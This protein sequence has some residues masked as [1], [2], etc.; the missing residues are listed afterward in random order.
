M[1]RSAL[2]LLENKDSDALFSLG[3]VLSELGRHDESVDAYRQGLTLNGDDAELCY[4]LAIKVGSMGRTSE[5]M[6][7]Y[8][9]ATQVD[10]SMG[11]AWLNWGTAL[12]EFGD[13]ESAEAKFL[14][15]ID[16][17]G[18]RDHD[19]VAAK[20]MMNLSILYHKVGERSAQSNDV[21]TAKLMATKAGSM[22]D[23]AKRRLDAILQSSDN[24]NS[25]ELEQYR[26]QFPSLRVRCH[27]LTGQLFA[28]AGSLTEAEAEFAKA[29]QSFPDDPMAWMMLSRVQQ[30]QGNESGAA[31]A[32]AN[33]A[34][35]QPKQ[36]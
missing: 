3:L 1:L 22:A 6:E 9:R 30:L 35:L 21:S 10:P 28:A 20:A 31:H 36:T 12:A 32:M 24:S 26:A 19:A 25:L 16:C 23:D 14:R 2:E 17:H 7:L 5:E 33:V 15:A 11:G 29:T 8:D 13:L 27:R 34:R 18:G 4:N